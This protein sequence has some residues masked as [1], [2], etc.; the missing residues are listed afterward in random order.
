[1]NGHERA[2]KTAAELQAPPA[3]RG[4]ITRAP[5][6][7]TANSVVQL[8]QTVGNQAVQHLLAGTS[9]NGAVDW[10]AL[11]AA[12]SFHLQKAMLDAELERDFNFLVHQI[13]ENLQLE[14]VGMHRNE[15]K[16][17]GILRR[18]GEEKFTTHPRAYPNGGDYLDKLFSKLYN[19]TK[20]LEGLF[21]DEWTNYYSLL[22]NHFKRDDELK[23][24]RDKY[25]LNFRSDSGLKELGSFASFLWE[26]VKEGR[27]RDRLKAF[28][29]GVK[30]GV[31][32]AGKGLATFAYTLVTDPGKAV[33]E[34]SHLP[35]NLKKLWEN[36][37]ELWQ[38]FVSAT[39]E[40]QAEMIGELIGQAEFAIATAPVGGLA[41]EGLSSLAQLPGLIG[42]VARAL[43]VITSIPGKIVGTAAKGVGITLKGAAQGAI[44]AAR[45]VYK[46]GGK[47]LRGTWSVVEQTVGKVTRKAF[48]FWDDA[49]ERLIPVEEN[50]AQQSMKNIETQATSSAEAAVS[51]K[52]TASGVRSA[53]DEYREFL[54][55]LE[56]EGGTG[57]TAA[58]EPMTMQPHGGARQARQTVG[59]TGEHQSAH[60]LPRS[61]GR[62]IPGYDPNAALTTLEERVLH[63]GIDQYWKEAF[64]AMRREGRTMASAKEIYDVV[65][66]SIQRAPNLSQGLKDTMKLRL[67]DEMF[68]ELG[69][70]YGNQLTLPYPNIRP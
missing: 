34:L 48:Y 66:E 6:N 70:G 41:A 16:V 63:A 1:M 58:G 5:G 43:Q 54:S 23:E 52:G 50:V 44:W 40:K 21:T 24:I 15:E 9:A 30:E 8:Q 47:V 2:A 18:W 68:T 42:K 12:G 60:G 31:K 51:S 38:K 65:S 67:H 56:E 11:L 36:R 19:K 14:I 49:A 29:V 27:I 62:D 3:S 33:D 32:S 61:V 7:S 22:F 53:D 39:P 10:N 35:G 37:G 25:S 20:I 4:E 64:Q 46:F 57:L 17:L 26:D 55:M 28:A 69:L 45:G 13:D 59:V